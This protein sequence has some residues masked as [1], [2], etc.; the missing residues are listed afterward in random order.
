ME[1]YNGYPVYDAV[2]DDE[3]FT[4]G[5]SMWSFINKPA[6]DEPLFKFGKH[7]ED[8]N[9]L[10]GSFNFDIT[11]IDKD[12]RLIRS[13]GMLADTKIFRDM[14]GKK[15]YMKFPPDVVERMA[16]K[17]MKDQHTKNVNKEHD[18]ADRINDVYV[19]ETFLH[20]E[21]RNGALPKYLSHATPGSWVLTFKVEN[22][23]LM[24]DINSGKIN[25]ISLEGD[26][27]LKLNFT[28]TFVELDKKIILASDISTSDKFDAIRKAVDENR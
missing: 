8:G 28:K 10:D 4:A 23:E 2:L 20:N 22:D 14:M 13:I 9:I 15:F 26:F 5:V 11:D 6:T 27:G 18:A 16:F 25:G 12:K 19:V 17:F 21:E 7:D 1:T 24:N 3:K